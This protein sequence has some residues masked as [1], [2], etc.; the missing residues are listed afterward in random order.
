MDKETIK[1][2]LANIRSLMRE[3]KFIQAYK[4]LG[5]VLKNL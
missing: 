5:F 3:G 1:G 2:Y 4:E